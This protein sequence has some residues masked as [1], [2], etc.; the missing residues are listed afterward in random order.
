MAEDAD[1][2]VPCSNWRF[3]VTIVLLALLDPVV[4]SFLFSSIIFEGNPSSIFL[5]N[6][7]LLHVYLLKIVDRGEEANMELDDGSSKIPQG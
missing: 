5:W 7:K 4:S 3:E 6:R 1:L 2:T